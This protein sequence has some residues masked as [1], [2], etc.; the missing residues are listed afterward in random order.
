MIVMKKEEVS[1]HKQTRPINNGQSG[2][3]VRTVWANVVVVVHRAHVKS[4]E[5]SRRTVSTLQHAGMLSWVEGGREG[6]WRVRRG[7]G[8][9]VFE[10]ATSSIDFMVSQWGASAVPQAPFGSVSESAARASD[11]EE[12]AG[13]PSGIGGYGSTALAEQESDAL[14]RSGGSIQ[15]TA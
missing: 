7:G 6:G 2:R 15:G 10:V 11:E 13:G 4:S 12:E 9:G 8:D 14:L 1:S 3:S 5:R